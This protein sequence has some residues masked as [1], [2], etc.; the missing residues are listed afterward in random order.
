MPPS[1]AARKAL[2]ESQIEVGDVEGSGRRG[3]V[4]KP[5]VADAIAK[6]EAVPQQSTQASY[7]PAPMPTVSQQL[8][9]LRS[10]R[11]RAKSG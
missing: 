2:A 7:V 5:D 3:Q 9:I 11:R 6:R 10:A 4:L 1:P 8:R